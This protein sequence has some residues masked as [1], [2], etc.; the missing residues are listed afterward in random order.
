MIA[1]LAALA[2]MEIRDIARRNLRAALFAAAAAAAA[3]AALGYALVGLSAYLTA[4]H[5]EIA[6]HLMVGGGLLAVAMMFWIVAMAARRAPG[7]KAESAAALIGAPIALRP[8]ESLTPSLG[9][10]LPLALMA[11]IVAGRV[12]TRK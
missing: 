1:S 2:G 8:G 4:I 11:G 9:R 10:T 3:I 5:G 6:A 12:L 7:R